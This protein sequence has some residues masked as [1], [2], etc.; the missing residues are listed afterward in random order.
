MIF[1]NIHEKGHTLLING[2]TIRTPSIV[3]ITM[4]NE[5]LIQTELKKYGVSHYSIEFIPDHQIKKN[6]KPIG[7]LKKEKL[8]VENISPNNE[9]I[10]NRLIAIES[11]LKQLI[12]KPESKSVTYVEAQQKI[13]ELTNKT[14]EADIG[15]IPSIDT[16]VVLKGPSKISKVMKEEMDLDEKSKSLSKFFKP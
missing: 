11:L 4:L 16:D 7:K 6:P 8:K 14:L 13:K 12:N 15:F 10:E 1:L 5:K 3:D 2:R 9:Q